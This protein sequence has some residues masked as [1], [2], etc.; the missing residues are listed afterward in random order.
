MRC[1]YSVSIVATF[2]FGG[3]GFQEWVMRRVDSV[4][5]EHFLFF[6]HACESASRVY[7]ASKRLRSGCGDGPTILHCSRK[8]RNWKTKKG[9]FVGTGASV[10]RILPHSLGTSLGLAQKCKFLRWGRALYL[11]IRCLC[12]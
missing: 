9:D 4:E 11:D 2:F 12:R 7:V 8:L 5:T 6:K 3:G 1:V 10:G